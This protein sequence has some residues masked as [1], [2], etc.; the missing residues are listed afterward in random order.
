LN[1]IEKIALTKRKIY[2]KNESQ[3]DI[4]LF[5]FKLILFIIL[6]SFYVLVS[7]INFKNKNIILIYFQIKN[8]LKNNYYHN[9]KQALYLPHHIP[10]SYFS[11]EK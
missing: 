11:K 4:L 2:Q 3:I 10:I 6:E 7:K 1:Q 9:T 5:F 8:T